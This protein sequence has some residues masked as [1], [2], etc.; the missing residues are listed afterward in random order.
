META[1][2]LG[3]FADKYFAGEELEEIKKSV[4]GYLDEILTKELVENFVRGKNELQEWER[5]L[6]N[7]DDV[8]TSKVRDYEVLC[9]MLQANPVR[10]LFRRI[11]V[12]LKN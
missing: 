2:T 7:P 10:R 11:M 9:A 5:Q 8:D 12:G 1:Q 4:K 6:E 3:E